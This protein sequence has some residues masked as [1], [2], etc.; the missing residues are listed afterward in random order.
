MRVRRRIS[1]PTRVLALVLAGVIPLVVP[2][3]RLTAQPSALNIF[4]VYDDLN[5]L[6]AVIDQQGN[7]ATYTYDAVGNILKIERFDATALPDRVAIT[8]V[9]PIKGEIGDAVQ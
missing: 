5:R 3:E 4:Y 9:S 6:V 7:T 2:L 8:L 1:V